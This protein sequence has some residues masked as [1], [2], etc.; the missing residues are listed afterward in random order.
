ML[1][2]IEHIDLV[3]RHNF[4]VIQMF[5]ADVFTMETEAWFCGVSA[6]YY[7]ERAVLRYLFPA[8]AIVAIGTAVNLA[9][10]GCVAPVLLSLGAAILWEVPV[11]L[12]VTAILIFVVARLYNGIQI[13]KHDYQYWIPLNPEYSRLAKDNRSFSDILQDTFMGMRRDITIK[14]TTEKGE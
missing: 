13:L 14:K 8:V 9:V 3:M 1:Q 6:G 4:R 11:A 5:N 10:I 7:I 2:R 12:A